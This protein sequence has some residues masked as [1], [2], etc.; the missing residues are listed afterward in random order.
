MEDTQNELEQMRA[1]LKKANEEAKTARHER[2]A[3]QEQLQTAQADSERFRTGYIQ[4]K[5]E[6]TLSEAGVSNGKAAK[7]L[8][9]SKVTVMD[10]G[11]L[12]GLAEQLETLKEDLPELFAPDRP[13]GIRGADAANKQEIRPTKSTA[14]AVVDA[15]RNR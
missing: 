2:N 11:D 13:N 12:E 9:Y 4:M 7:F 1:A 3:L 14:N 15:W 10:T 6:R 8:D 5:A